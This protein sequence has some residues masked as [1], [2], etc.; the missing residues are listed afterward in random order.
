MKKHQQVWPKIILAIK[1]NSVIEALDQKLQ[2]PVVEKFKKGKVYARY[3][4]S[5]WAAD[6]TETILL[7]SKTEITNIYLY[8]LCVR[9][10][11]YQICLG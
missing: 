3:K 4:D 5:I 8:I 7:P 9:D 6:L 1:Q 11:F 10:A 2:K